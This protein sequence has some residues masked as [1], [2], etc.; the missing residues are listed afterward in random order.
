MEFVNQVNQVNQTSENTENSGSGFA[1]QNAMLNEQNYT[2]TANGALTHI[3]TMDNLVDLFYKTTRNAD[4]RNIETIMNKAV[5]ESDILVAKM[6]AYIRDIRG[7][8][9]ERELGKKMLVHMAIMRPDIVSKNIKHYVHEY[10]RWDDGLY[11]ME[12]PH[13]EQIYLNAVKEQLNE[14]I[15][16]L[17]EKGE[18]ANISLC[19]KWVPTEGK[20]DDKKYKFTKKLC[21][22]MGINQAHLRTVFIAPLRRHLNLIETKLMQKDYENI[23]YEKVPSKC[24]HLHGKNINK[25]RTMNAFPRNDGTRFT[26]YLEK[27]K[28]GK[29]KVNAKTLYPHE[30][31]EHYFDGRSL[32]TQTEDILTEGQWKVMEEKMRSLG[33]I[34]KTMC[35]CDVSG[36]MSGIPMQISI[37]LGILIS[38]CCEVE[39]FKDFILTFSS[40]PEFHK[41]VGNNLVEKIGSLSRAKWEMSTDFFLAFKKILDTAVKH[42]LKPED[43]PERL[44]VIS[45][46]Q[47]N[48]ANNNKTTNFKAID[49]LYQKAGYKR[50]QLIFWNVNG[51]T[52]ET[53]VLA[54]TADTG[55]I[56]G[57]SP[58]LLKAVLNGDSFTPKDLMLKAILDSRY[59]LITL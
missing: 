45:D 28:E 49:E 4:F 50:P 19:A 57:Y 21:R 27:L 47:F 58:E 26:E 31:M 48:C 14:D 7:G 18:K 9:G 8:K 43:M 51:N 11:L 10:G 33:K 5:A 2:T 37:S 39:A 24:M 35:L 34:G 42:S 17:Q 23:D 25:K 13:L 6:I 12:H 59:D 53:P 1:F 29:A 55:L 38:S 20:A 32:K 40:V 15:N 44:I 54:N 3:S 16:E 56:S 46:M 36:S 22:F 52:N 30:I 41:I